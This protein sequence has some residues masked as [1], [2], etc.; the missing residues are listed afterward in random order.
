VLKAIGFGRRVIFATLLAEAAILA[1]VAGGLGVALAVT[2]TRGL[3]VAS[4]WNDAIGPLGNFIVSAPVIVDG[5]FL[6]L[7]VGMLS[8][9]VPAL[10]ASR[11]PVVESLHEVF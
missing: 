3:K 7:F 8:G 9:V 1:T 10:G 5:L 11:K 6:S 2:L 4:G